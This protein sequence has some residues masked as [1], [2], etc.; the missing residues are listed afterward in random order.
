MQEA[1]RRP[2]CVTS[3][4]RPA[5]VVTGVAGKDIETVILENDV[6]FWRELD[7]R[8]EAGHAKAVTIEE[9]RAG[10]RSYAKRVRR[11]LPAKRK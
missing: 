7:R 8:T 3:H 6:S 10:K 2:V 11:A 4:G 9:F 5:A 1:Q